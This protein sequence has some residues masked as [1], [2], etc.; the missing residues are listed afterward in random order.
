MWAVQVTSTGGLGPCQVYG[1]VPS[2]SSTRLGGADLEEG[3]ATGASEAAAMACRA[4]LE[5][6]MRGSRAAAARE[7]RG[8]TTNLCCSRYL[9][10]GRTFGS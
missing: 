5:R 6:A 2:N 1:A 8:A 3:G 7:G 10:L 9:A 4:S